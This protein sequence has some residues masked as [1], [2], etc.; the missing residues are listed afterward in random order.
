MHD[1]TT[2]SIGYSHPLRTLRSHH[3]FKRSN[4]LTQLSISAKVDPQQMR[5]YLEHLLLL[6]L[7]S[8]RLSQPTEQGEKH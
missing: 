1:P 6:Q 4:A 7:F 8:G 5:T 2:E 3:R